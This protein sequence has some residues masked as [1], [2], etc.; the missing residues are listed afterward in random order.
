MLSIKY[1]IKLMEKVNGIGEDMMVNSW[2][3]MM[4]PTGLRVN[5]HKIINKELGERC[6]IREF[7]KRKTSVF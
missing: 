2:I 4:Y 7:C 5:I 3:L 1:V 6:A